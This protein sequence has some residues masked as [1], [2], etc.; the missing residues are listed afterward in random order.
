MQS[1]RLAIDV[2]IFT[3]W[4]TSYLYVNKNGEGIPVQIL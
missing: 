2:I 3:S 4:D 1:I